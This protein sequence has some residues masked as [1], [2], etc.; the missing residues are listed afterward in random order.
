MRVFLHNVQEK[1]GVVLC[2]IEAFF[3][4]DRTSYAGYV[5]FLGLISLGVLWTGWQSALIAGG[6]HEG[7]VFQFLPQTLPLLFSGTLHIDRF[8]GVFGV[9]LS[10]V[11]LLTFTEA[12]RVAFKKGIFAGFFVL[13]TIASSTPFT[14][15][16]WLVATTVFYV[17]HVAQSERRSFV[18][19]MMAIILSVLLLSGGAF[20]ADMTI[21]ATV[22]SQLP[23]AIVSLA[24]VL[25]F[26]GSFWSIRSFEGA[27]VLIPIYIA[28]RLCLFFLV[29]APALL[30]TVVAVIA[31]FAA[32]Y[33][34][35]STESSAP[36]RASVY[37]LF[38]A[39]PL[40]M[41]AVEMQLIDAVQCFLFGGLAVGTA[42][43]VGGILTA[44]PTR[45]RMGVSLLSRFVQSVLPGTFMGTGAFLL[46]AGFVSLG[47]L[48][49]PAEM[50][51]LAFLVFLV[52]CTFLFITRSLLAYEVRT[53]PWNMSGILQALILLAGGVFFAQMLAY[54]GTTI[55]GDA[56][57]STIAIVLGTI[58]FS[59]TPWIFLVVSAGIVVIF[60][61]LKK[62]QSAV[63]GRV[64]QGVRHVFACLDRW[65]TY[66]EHLSFLR[67]YGAKGTSWLEVSVTSLE[68]RTARMKL[69]ER[70]LLMVALFI[71]T[72]IVLF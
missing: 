43:I 33:T 16:A 51:Y 2:R 32:L 20:L 68:Q 18:V 54:L 53:A 40:T 48:A 59:F 15:V 49:G 37:I 11:L 12:S 27:Y 26:G 28:L 62:Y 64:V 7:T 13:G 9:I 17:K 50:V 42:G 41:I 65:F 70:G 36:A 19:S 63:W 23:V 8:A 14:L 39:I 45:M 66:P 3:R 67:A 71:V 55:G 35:R 47:Q 24:L 22:S 1:I 31:I 58:T 34:A 44:W 72:I 5:V 56:P 38:M 60:M 10:I 61:A 6:L 4:A 25:L 57:D 29:S 69:Q 46:L 30:L 52:L 21:V